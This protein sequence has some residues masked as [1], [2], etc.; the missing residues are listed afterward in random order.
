[1]KKI[2]SIL[3][4]LTWGI[5]AFAQGFQEE[6]HEL[7][8]IGQ[9][10]ISSISDDEKMQANE[11]F[12]K[13]LSTL[14]NKP[15][16]FDTNLDS[17]K[18]IS[19]LQSD[20]LK[21]YNWTIP[22]SDGTYQYF[23]FLQIKRDKSTFQ[24]VE[25]IDKSEEINK[26]ETK[27]LT[28]NS[29]YGALYYKLIEEKK[30][31]TQVYTL[32]G[33]DGNNLLTNKKIIDVISIDKNGNIKLGAPVFKAKRKTYKRVIFEYAENAV[34]S[35]KYHQRSHQ[36]VFDYLVPTSS[37]LTGIYEYYGPALN[38]FD[39]YKIEKKGWVY[40][41]DIDIELDKSIKDFIWNDPKEE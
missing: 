9:Q 41:E 25:L 3:L 19:I 7:N 23:A 17:L 32:L 6:I 20:Q 22:F 35:L 18:T 28:P 1:M 12:K 36:I 31:G 27:I 34:M 14:I 13:T 40:Q 26:P 37:N 38:R 2:T 11:E 21:I 8:R 16:S 10:L 33:W 29:W 39:S 24:T 15:A 4:C 5:S 30:L